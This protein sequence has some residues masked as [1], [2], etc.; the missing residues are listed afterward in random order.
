MGGA[1]EGESEAIAGQPDGFW[2]GQLGGRRLGGGQAEAAGRLGR[3][4]QQQ[5]HRWRERLHFHSDGWPQRMRTA[6]HG[7]EGE[8]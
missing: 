3:C 8:S 5:P 7:C 2:L 6:R 1:H 4:G